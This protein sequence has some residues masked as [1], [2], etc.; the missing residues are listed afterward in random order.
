MLLCQN[1]N[2]L[3][4][5]FENRENNLLLSE[6]VEEH[7]A[8]FSKEEKRHRIVHHRPLILGKIAV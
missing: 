8:S 7:L 5:S 2:L 6:K 4:A 3:R 1:T